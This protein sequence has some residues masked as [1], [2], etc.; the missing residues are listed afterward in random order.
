MDR[1]SGPAWAGIGTRGLPRE[2]ALIVLLDR[3]SHAHL[4]QGL[5]F[6][7]DL[8][9]SIPRHCRDSISSNWVL[10]LDN[11][12]HVTTAQLRKARI[13]RDLLLPQLN[14][15]HLPVNISLRIVGNDVDVRV[16]V[17]RF[18]RRTIF[19]HEQGRE[20]LATRGK[21]YRG[22]IEGLAARVVPR[23]KDFIA[24]ICHHDRDLEAFN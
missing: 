14:T 24:S 8:S 10:W 11:Q 20:K 6:R 12:A 9:D 2:T 21:F 19:K 4:K 1:N 17:A 22:D 7:L 23:I 16:T 3:R 15:E 13:R 18:V 5:S